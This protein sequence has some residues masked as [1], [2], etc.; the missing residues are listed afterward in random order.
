MTDPSSST[1]LE[2]AA[3]KG[4]ADIVKLLLEHPKI[5]V[6]GSGLAN[7]PAALDVLGPKPRHFRKLERYR[8]GAIERCGFL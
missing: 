7:G 8:R 4:H 3:F 2:I 6:N 5:K 1:S